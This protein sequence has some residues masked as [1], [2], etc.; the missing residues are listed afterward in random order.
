MVPL[1]NSGA[2][3]V[4]RRLFTY[5]T[6]HWKVIAWAVVAMVPLF[7]RE[8]LRAVHH[9]RCHRDVGRCWPDR[10]ELHTSDPPGDGRGSWRDRLRCRLW[11]GL[12]GSGGSFEICVA[13]C[14]SNT[15][16]SLRVFIDQESTGL[17]ISK[18]TYNTEQ[19]AEAIS[20]V[21]SSYCQRHSDD[22]RAYWSND[23]L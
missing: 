17:L 7:C 16:D 2:V 9:R 10:R 12:A 14:S 13:R 4:Y 19:V 15:R 11:P 20:N 5:V 1:L 8:R 22:A 3:S 6:P 21:S 23:L 18:L